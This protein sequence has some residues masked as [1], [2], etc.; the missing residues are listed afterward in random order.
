MRTQVTYIILLLVLVGCQKENKLTFETLSL[1]ETRC[2]ECPNV[3]INIP[4]ALENS[5]IAESINTAIDEEIIETLNYDDE[6]EATSI[7]DAV[8]SFSNGYWELKKLYPE[9]A[10]SWEAKIEGKVSYENADFISIELNSY[11]FTG[12]AHGYSSQHFLNFDKNKAKELENWEIFK[13]RKDFE[14]FAEQK[15]RNQEKIP[16]EGPINS[17]GFM[18]ES[19]TFYLPENIGFT[20]EGIKLLYNPYEVA[21]YADGPIVLTLPFTDLKPYLVN[22]KS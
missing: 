11:I 17:T 12:G 22:S 4:K 13:D 9:E 3:E 2:S 20:K 8:Q 6:L 15:F 16:L 1:D 5:K 10:T 14:Q 18:F 7:K 19:D 21:S